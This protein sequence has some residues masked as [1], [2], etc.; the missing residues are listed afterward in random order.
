MAGKYLWSSGN[1]VY[2]CNFSKENSETRFTHFDQ[3]YTLASPLPL[4]PEMLCLS[5]SDS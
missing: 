4:T 5:K 3:S 2:N 1:L